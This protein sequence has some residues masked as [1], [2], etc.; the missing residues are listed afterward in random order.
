MKSATEVLVVTLIVC[1]LGEATDHFAQTEVDEMDIALRE[2]EA[3]SGSGDGSRAFGASSGLSSITGLLGQVPGAGDLVHQAQDLQAKSD[4]QKD[5]VA[6][7]QIKA[8]GV[9][10]NTTTGAPMQNIP[11]TNIDPVKT[12]KNIYPILEFRDKVAKALAA[13]IEKIPGLEALVEKITETLTLFILSLLAPFIRPI[14]KAVSKQLKAGSGGVIDASGRSQYEP[15]TDPHCS[16]PT[17]SLL[18]KDHFSNILNEPAGQVASTILQYVAPRILYAWEHPDVPVEQVL[19]D[20]IRVFHHPVIRDPHCEIHRNMFNTVERWVQTYRGTSLNQILSSD[21]VRHGRNQTTQGGDHGHHNKISNM[22]PNKLNPANM[23]PSSVSHMIGSRSQSKVSDS[24]WA[25]IGRFRE[26][27]GPEGSSAGAVDDIPNAFPG[28]QTE[29]DSSR[30]P[31]GPNAGYAA[32]AQ[33]QAQ[34]SQQQQQ[35]PYAQPP[36]PLGASGPSDL[37]QQYSQQQAPPPQWQ[38]HQPQP[39]PG[40]EPPGGQYPPQQGYPYGYDPN[41]PPPQ[42]QQPY[43]YQGPPPPPGGYYG[44][45]PP[46]PQY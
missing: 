17:H 45:A 10:A 34:P 18:S 9:P 20:V 33:S 11:G 36:H 25:T 27:G 21:S 3:R 13:T 4:E 1:R 38:Q 23:L 31:A 7:G 29:Y 6:S 42:Q 44:G 30:P 26:M 14:I 39:Y 2:A 35:D 16:D 5:A 28:T 8:D 46:P 15:W 40:Q 12:A 37:Q 19:N 43:G 41:I 24:P 22:I 32:A